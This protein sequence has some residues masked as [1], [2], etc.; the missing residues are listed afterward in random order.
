MYAVLSGGSGRDS[1]RL[2]VFCLLASAVLPSLSQA[3]VPVFV[4]TPEE[5]T[6]KL[7]VKSSVDIEGHFDIWDATLIFTSPKISTG[8]LDIKIQATSVHFGSGFMND[9]LESKDFLDL[10]HDPLITFKSTKIVRT[11]PTTYQAQGNLTI[12]G[13]TKTDTLMLTVESLGKG[14]SEITG[15]VAFNRK[16]YGMDGIIPLVI[17]ADRAEVTIAFQANLVS[18]TPVIFNQ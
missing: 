10:E 6:I 16:D 13:V 18:G 17:I 15:T 9:R 12:R 1:M 8:D 3:Q 14:V 2:A 7:H 5:C 4:L 11:S